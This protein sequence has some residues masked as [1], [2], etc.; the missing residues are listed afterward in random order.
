VSELGDLEKKAGSCAEE[1]P[2]QVGNDDQRGG[3]IHQAG[4]RA[5]ARLA[6]CRAVDASE[7][8]ISGHEQGRRAP[9]WDVKCLPRAGSHKPPAPGGIIQP[10]C[11][12]T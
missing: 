8:R 12:G 1:H 7:K 10:A 4:D 6:N 2:E 3:K 9:E 11:T 5:S